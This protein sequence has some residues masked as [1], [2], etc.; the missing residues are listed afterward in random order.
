MQREKLYNLQSKT[1]FNCTLFVFKK[2]KIMYDQFS[3]LRKI[4]YF[5]YKI[6]CCLHIVEL[7]TLHLF[8]YVEEI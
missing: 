2:C 8:V 3:S 7:F 5:M 1:Y 4:P 6:N